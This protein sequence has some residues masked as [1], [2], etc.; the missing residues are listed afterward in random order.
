MGSGLVLVG[1]GG[2]TRS[3]A[4]GDVRRII[5]LLARDSR[6]DLWAN[7]RFSIQEAG[8]T[9]V[10]FGNRTI[11]DGARAYGK[12][13]PHRRACDRRSRVPGYGTRRDQRQDGCVACMG[14][15]TEGWVDS[16]ESHVGGLVGDTLRTW[17]RGGQWGAEL[18][19]PPPVGEAESSEDIPR[20]DG[21]SSLGPS[22][23]WPQYKV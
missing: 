14:F 12:H 1:R 23:P 10:M 4:P 9:V 6:A 13:R 22:F 8:K 7:A 21:D 3:P 18:E 5:S 17:D 19:P 15:E 20:H 2:S 11:R 16:C